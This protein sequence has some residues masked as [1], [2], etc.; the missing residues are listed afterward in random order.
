MDAA[1]EAGKAVKS[2]YDL[3]ELDI[4]FEKFSMGASGAV[5]QAA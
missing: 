3:S 2:D 5:T 4:S 1:P